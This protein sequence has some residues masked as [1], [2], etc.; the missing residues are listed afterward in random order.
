MLIDT[1]IHTKRHSGCSIIDPYALVKKVKDLPIDGIVITEHNYIWRPDERD[2]LRAYCPDVL[3]L[4]GMEINCK[5]SLHYLVFYDLSRLSIPEMKLYEYMDEEDMFKEVHRN[6]GA[7]VAAHM[8]RYDRRVEVSD[9]AK[10]PI[11]GLEA[12][13]T[14]ISYGETLKILDIADTLNLC[15]IAGSDA[16]RIDDVG[17]FLTIFDCKIS[18]EADLIRA[19]KTRSCRAV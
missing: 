6:D 1:H 13:S 18:N 19:I 14:N 7:V 9:V 12:K 5:H 11:D 3:I 10:T 2:E 17:K 4:F 15:T 16:H 8:L